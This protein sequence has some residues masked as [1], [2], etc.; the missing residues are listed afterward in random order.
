[1]ATAVVTRAISLTWARTLLREAGVTATVAVTRED[2]YDSLLGG[3]DGVTAQVSGG[4]EQIDTAV[5]ALT[6]LGSGRYPI[7]QEYVSAPDDTVTARLATVSTATLV[8]SFLVAAASAGLTAAANVLDRRRVYGLLRLA[9][10]P[11]EVL[12]RARIRETVIPLT[13]LAG[14]TTAMGA[15]GAMQFDKAAGTTVDAS[16]AVQLVVCVAVGAL[17]V[18]AAIAGSRPLLRKVTAGPA[19]TAD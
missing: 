15:F 7:T 13:V 5:T 6:P 8:L 3:V 11:L 18:L 12:D 9:G 19:Q 14:G 4:Q 10:T 17:A 16:G 2:D 1:M